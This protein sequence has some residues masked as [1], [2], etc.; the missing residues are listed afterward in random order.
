MLQSSLLVVAQHPLHLL[1]P[2][3][4]KAKIRNMVIEIEITAE[5][6]EVIVMA[7][8]EIVVLVVTVVAPLL[9]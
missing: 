7:N 3:L 1:V 6:E 8:T 9:L 2:S 5:K 4:N